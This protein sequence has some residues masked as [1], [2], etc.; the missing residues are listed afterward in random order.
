MRELRHPRVIAIAQQWLGQTRQ[1]A[2]ELRR[3]ARGVGLWTSGERATLAQDLEYFADL[4]TGTV[5][6]LQPVMPGGSSTT[7]GETEE[8]RAL[9][10]LGLRAPEAKVRAVVNRH[11]LRVLEASAW[12]GGLAAR[13]LGVN[14]RTIERFAA[15]QKV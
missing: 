4:L 9:K 11:Y 8:E 10:R 12:K 6:W 3:A 7:E 1:A 14:R 2:S 13:V 15:S 5:L